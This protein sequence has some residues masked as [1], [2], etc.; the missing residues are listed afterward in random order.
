MKHSNECFIRYAQAPRRRVKEDL[1]FSTHAL[2]GYNNKTLF[3]K[4]LIYSFKD[5]CLLLIL[6][7]RSA[8]LEILGFLRVVPTNKTNKGMCLRG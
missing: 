1:V 3:P 7:M 4:G 6:R 8:H 5:G 2:L